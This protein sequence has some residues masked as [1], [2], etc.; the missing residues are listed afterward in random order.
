MD[1]KEVVKTIAEHFGVTAKYLG[2]PSF[3]FEIRTPT[4]TYTVDRLGKIKNTEGLEM[5]LEEILNPTITSEE[6]TVDETESRIKL[7]IPIAG[8]TGVTLRNFVNMIY[9]KQGL[10]KKVFELEEDIISEDFVKAINEARIET[11]E[12]FKN[13]RADKYGGLAFD[14]YTKIMTLNFLQNLTDIKLIEA[15]YCMALLI[16]AKAKTQKY[17]SAK[18]KTTDNDKFA[19]RTWLNSL[20]MI[21]DDY[22]ETRKLLL[23]NLKGSSAFRY[24]V[25]ER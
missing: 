4:E 15:G 19:F 13:I 5:Q 18:I 12:D 17:A 1:R 16:N 2:T 21:G 25:P 6:N 14:F 10:M 20:G 3:A 11:L 24:K 23:K 9:S 8:H 22:S 7:S